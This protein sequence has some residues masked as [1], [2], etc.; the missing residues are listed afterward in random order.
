MNGYSYV[1]IKFYLL[2]EI[3]SRFGP[4]PQFASFPLE[5]SKKFNIHSPNQASFSIL[6]FRPHREANFSSLAAS[7]VVSSEYLRLLIF[8]PTI[9]IPAYASSSLA[10]CIMYSAY[11][12]SK[13]GDNVQPWGTPFPIWNQS[14]V[15]YPV[16]T[17]ASWPAYRFFRRQVR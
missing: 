4:R 7:R 15:P 12:L 1:S 10:F 3:M 8:L 9:L 5:D 6:L 17:V 14:V 16:L 13:Q 11:K 2:K